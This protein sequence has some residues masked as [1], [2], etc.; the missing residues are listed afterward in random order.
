MSWE[1]NDHDTRPTRVL[2]PPAPPPVLRFHLLRDYSGP[3]G[4][5]CF[6]SYTVIMRNIIKNILIITALALSPGCARS[7]QPVC[8]HDALYAAGT[9]AEDRPVWVL[10][11]PLYG[12]PHAVAITQVKGRPHHLVLSGGR[13]WARRGLPK[14]FT[15]RDRLTF[16]Q[17]IKRFMDWKDAEF[18][19][20]RSARSGP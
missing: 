9:V 14:G 10:I 5:Y 7:W 11:G 2:W 19:K 6:N 13:V 12:T 8:R 3:R 1:R 4:L 20:N 17:Y 18:I 16:N 15:S